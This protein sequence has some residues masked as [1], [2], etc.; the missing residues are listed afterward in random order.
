MSRPVPAARRL[1][2]IAVIAV[3]APGVMLA[4][5]CGAGEPRSI[6]P[7]GVD[8]LEIPTATPDPADFV[9]T[10]DNP[11]LPFAPGNTC[12]TRSSRAARSPRRSR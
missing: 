6:D 3:V 8:G 4:S 7:A 11:Y 2:R 1:V 10:I 9:R 5:G 12:A